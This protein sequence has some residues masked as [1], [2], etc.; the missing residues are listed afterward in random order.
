MTTLDAPKGRLVALPLE[1]HPARVD[2]RRSPDRRSESAVTDLVA[3]GDDVLTAF[4]AHRRRTSLVLRTR[5]GV[6]SLHHHA[7]DG[8]HLADITDV[9]GGLA[10]VTGLAAHPQRARAR[11]GGAHVLHPA[12]HRH[13]LAARRRRRSSSPRLPGPTIDAGH[14]S[15]RCATRRPTAPPCRCCSCTP[16]TTTIDARTPTLLTGYGGFNITETPAWSPF[17]AAWC[18]LGG[19][20]ADPRPARRRRGGRGLAPGR[21]ARQQAAGVRRLRGRRRL[22]GRRG[23]HVPRSPGHP[24]RLQRRAAGGG[25]QGPPARPVRGRR[26]RRARS[27]TWCASRGSSS[28]A[29][30]SPSTATP[31]CPR[32]W[33]GSTPT[34]R[35][36]RSSTAP[37]YPATLVTTGEEDSRVDPCHARKMAARLQAA[38][39]NDGAAPRG[40][41]GRPRP[42]QARHQADRGASRRPR[43]P[44]LAARPSD[45]GSASLPERDR[46]S[47]SAGAPVTCDGG[48]TAN[49]ANATMAST[50]SS[51]RVGSW[52]KS[53]TARA[54]A[55]SR[56]A[57]GVVGRR[58][59]EARA[60]RQL[61][62][63][64]LGVVDQQVDVRGQRQRGVVV[65]PP[66]V[67]PGTE[68]RRAVVGQVGDRRAPVADA[69]AEGAAALVRDLQG[70]HLEAADVVLAG[71]EALEGPRAPQALGPDREVR[72][73]HGPAQHVD[74][75][76]R[77]RPGRGGTA[78][79]RRRR[80]R[81]RART[82]GPGCGPSAGDRGASAP[83]NGCLAEQRA[84]AAQPGA[85][86]EHEARR[87]RRR[88]PARRTRCCRRSARRRARAPGST[89]AR[90][91][92]APSRGRLAPLAGG[93]R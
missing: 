75:R 87:A 64:V 15:A 66:A 68:R 36:T 91:A 2:G 42:G 12:R 24:R 48:R 85:G 21:H 8:A 53:S 9:T 26:V 81:R 77:R 33:P 78:A 44:R 5:A 69:V 22:A 57:H 43:L 88:G 51:V 71:L 90:R 35:T 84:E 93:P 23:P 55:S 70:Q 34:R 61:L 89:P 13:G 72:R 65:R 76:R 41:R 59:A 11:R 7:A 30:G 67:G 47:P 4:A 60:R 31:T 79:P 10:A 80:G 86:V 25:L 14:A 20:V 39:T 3:E 63:G 50:S 1:G 40:G 27:P 45:A 54:P 32:S 18:E 6:S 56:Q 82:A 38:S 49:A 92:R 28:P 83:R 16:P 62:G 19:Q 73:R 52:W 17:I 74:R 29:S 37:R 58:V 46:R